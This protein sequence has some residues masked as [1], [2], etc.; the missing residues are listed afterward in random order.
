MQIRFACGCAV[1]FALSFTLFVSLVSPAAADTNT[2]DRSKARFDIPAED[3]GKALRDFAMQANCNLSYDPTSVQHLKAPAVKGEFTVPDALALILRGTHLRAV[4]INENTIQV[5]DSSLSTVESNSPRASAITRLAY[6]TPDAQAPTTVPANQNPAAPTT[7]NSAD[8]ESKTSGLEEIVVTGTNISGIENKTVP[9]LSFDRDAIERSGYA[10]LSDFITALPQNTKSGTNS[11]DGVL[12]GIT[13]RF[14]NIEN[15]TAANLRGLGSNSTLTLIN[16]HRIAASSFGTGVDLSMIPLSAVERIEVLTDGSSAVYGSDAVGGVVNIILRK[17]FSGEET[18]ARLDTLSRGGGAVKQIGQSIGRTWSTGGALAVLQF[19]DSNA[20]GADQRTFTRS[21]PE[22]TDILPSSKRYS[23]VLSAHQDLGA[24]LEIFIDAVLEHDSGQ[25]SVTDVGTPPHEQLIDSKTNSTSANSGFRWQPFGDWHLEGNALFSQVDTLTAEDFIPAEPPYVNGTPYVNAIETI[26]EGD[27]K[28]DGTVWS[29]G[30]ASIKAAVGASYRQEEFSALPVFNQPVSRHVHAAFAELYA[31]LITGSSNIPFVKRLDLS[32]AI[33][34]DSYSDFGS[35]TDPRFGVFFSPIDQLDFRVAYSTSFRVPDPTELF[36]AAA[37]NRII[38]ESGIPQPG[39]PT[40]NTPVLFFGNQ[41]LHPETSRNLTAGLD[42]LP[43]ALPGTRFSLNYYRILYSNR[44]TVAP[45]NA[46]VFLNQDIYGPL[47]RQ[48][49]N[50]AAVAAFVA[51]IQPPQQVFDL[52]AGRTGLAGIR[53][54][55]NYG[56]INATREKAEG[57]DLGA[58]SL[59]NL[60]GQAKL[61]LDFNA[62]YIRELETAFC[63]TCTSTDLANSYGEPLKLRLRAG[64]G[65]SNGTISA[66]AAVNFANA[67]S[68]TNLEPPGRIAAFTTL[69]LTASWYISASGTTLSLNILNALNSNPPL[70]APAFNHIGYDPTNADP[71]GRTVSFQVRQ[72]W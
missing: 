8:D 46:T 50:D 32:A 35:K 19:E 41:T 29:S 54:G 11:A 16:G 17:D 43:T 53:Y 27:L 24:S 71:R 58:H 9:L 34:D 68:D 66:N 3:L 23:G 65:W 57:L 60:S 10:S 47:I 64:G 72:A 4:N 1:G 40:G 18:S 7:T 49:P 5:L 31:P 22:P 56:V 20:L 67:Y 30:D 37:A 39:D 44:I 36:D 55:Y 14:N 13:G 38:I 45:L 26:K 63:E 42:F 69:D 52:S 61:N 12:S 25:R 62:T 48:F 59:I 28:L 33:R 21:L 6:A 2:R 70:T 51:S 15:S